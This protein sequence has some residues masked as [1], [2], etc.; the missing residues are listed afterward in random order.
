[1]HGEGAV[2]NAPSVGTLYLFCSHS[3]SASYTQGGPDFRLSPMRPYS[4]RRWFGEPVRRVSVTVDDG[5]ADV[6]IKRL[7]SDARPRRRRGIGDEPA[8]HPP[9]DRQD[10]GLQERSVTR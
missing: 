10:S 7:I 1:M 5:T 4:I 6:L 9:A 8:R 2:L 3:A